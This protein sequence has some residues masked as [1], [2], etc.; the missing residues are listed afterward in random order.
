MRTY[1]GF[2]SNGAL[3]Y[4]ELRDDAVHVL[5]QPYWLG[6]AFNGK[7]IPLRDVQIGLPVAPAR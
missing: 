5:T 1:G 2:I 3:L 4:G 6:L 7:V